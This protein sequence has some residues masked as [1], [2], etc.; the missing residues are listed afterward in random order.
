[1]L[2]SL[3]DRRIETRGDFYVADNA[4]VIGSVILGHETSVWFNSVIRGDNDLI[5]IGDGSN[6]QD[7]AV[8]HADEGVPLLL[9]NKV[10]VGHHA[11]VH[12]CTIEDGCL[13]GINAVV[14]NRAV[15]GKGSLIGANALIPEGKIIPEHSLVV[16]SPGRVLR[17]LSDEDVADIARIASH[18]IDKSRLY[19]ERLQVQN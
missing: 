17:T 13:V 12:G 11:T 6:I 10:S 16:G 8:L 7:C 14:L 9:G 15:I 19:R 4:T 2:F 1:M 3:G 5:T 18:Y